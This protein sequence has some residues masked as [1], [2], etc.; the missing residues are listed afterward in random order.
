MMGDIESGM[1][2]LQEFMEQTRAHISLLSD[3]LQEPTMEHA[4]KTAHL[5]K[6][7]ALNITATRLA[8]AALNL[9]RSDELAPR[10]EKE[11]LYAALKKEYTLLG[12]EL[13]IEGYLK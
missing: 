2:L 9:E 5:I 8:D 4:R 7:G 13:K 10:N 11:A 3:D 1:I 6:G 12:E